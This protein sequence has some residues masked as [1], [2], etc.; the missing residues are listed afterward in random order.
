MFNMKNLLLRALL[1]LSIAVGAPAAL[2]GPMYR[3]AIDTSSLSGTGFLDLGFL[4][5][6]D[7]GSAQAT[8]RN[9]SG[10][11][12]AHSEAIGDVSGNIID[13]VRFGNGELDNLFDQAVNFGGL[14]SFDVSFDL[15]PTHSGVTFAVAL[16]NDALDAYLGADVH[17]L[18]IDLASGL[19]VDLT[20]FAPALADATELAEV[21]EPAAWL[22]LA[23]GLLLIGMT[24]RLQQR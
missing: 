22:L 17:L 6:A 2:A 4:S 23:A 16:M 3:V 18:T 1:A 12:L 9:F 5:L 7:A 11:F 10:D 24:R 13:G 19:P 14:F 8:V 21:P 15:L 20:V